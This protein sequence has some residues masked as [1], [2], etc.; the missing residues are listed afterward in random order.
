MDGA[1]RP[2]HDRA[3]RAVRTGAKRRAG[4]LKR[5]IRRIRRSPGYARWE[6][7]ILGWLIWLILRALR[8]TSR[9]ECHGF[10][11]L[12]RYWREGR[13]L[14]LAFWHGRSI[15]LPFA[16]RGRR[17]VIMNSTHRDGE[18][19]TQALGRF[20]YEAVRG[21]ARRGAVAGTLGLLRALRD[22]ADAALIPDGPRGPAG[23]AR[24]GAVELAAAAGAPLFPLSFSASRCVRLPTWDRMMVPLPGARVVCVAG[25]P[26][27]PAADATG[28][29]RQWRERMRVELER[30]LS[31]VTREADRLAGRRE[32]AC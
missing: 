13:P 9:L 31:E 32:E 29:R 6:T 24:A 5:G 25:S 11:L 30:R 1:G 23:V 27:E 15:M 26:I 17:A 10:E 16:Y 8:A 12:D 14:V 4:P 7:R 19:I 20:G 28:D 22:G 3:V 21:S 2:G 18:M